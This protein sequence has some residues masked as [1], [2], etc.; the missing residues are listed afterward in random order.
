MGRRRDLPLRKDWEKVKDQIMFNCC[1]AKFTQHEDLKKIL[2]DTG[3]ATL[4][5][6]TTNDRYWGDGGDGTGLYSLVVLISN[7]KK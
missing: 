7:R 2:L 4:V 6:H 3:D 5:E 1:L